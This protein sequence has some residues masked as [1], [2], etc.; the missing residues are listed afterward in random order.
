MASCRLWTFSIPATIA[1]SHAD[2]LALRHRHITEVRLLRTTVIQYVIVLIPPSHPP[3]PSLP[4]LCQVLAAETQRLTLRGTAQDA[5]YDG[6]NGNSA[7]DSIV[8]AQHSSEAA[9]VGWVGQGY[10]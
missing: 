3:L 9:L 8:L 4:Y 2:V 7:I 5:I 1:A 10:Q 6:T